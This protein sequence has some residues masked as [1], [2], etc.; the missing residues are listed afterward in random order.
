MKW[1]VV[2]ILIASQNIQR[3]EPI[4]VSE[5]AYLFAARDEVVGDALI[6]LADIFSKSK[7]EV[8]LSQ[9]AFFDKA[10]IKMWFAGRRKIISSLGLD[11]LDRVVG[12]LSES[13]VGVRLTEYSY[14]VATIEDLHALENMDLVKIT[15]DKLPKKIDK[16][17]SLQ[18]YWYLMHYVKAYQKL[19]GDGDIYIEESV[20]LFWN[21]EQLNDE[22]L[23]KSCEDYAIRLERLGHSEPL[24]FG[25]QPARRWC[26]GIRKIVNLPN[27]SILEGKDYEL[28]NIPLHESEEV[29]TNYLFSDDIFN[30]TEDLTYSFY[31]VSSLKDLE[32]FI[33][34]EVVTI[35][36]DEKS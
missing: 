9:N 18:M 2:H 21:K 6:D 7:A 27:F 32:K 33:N 3:P 20:N 12:G 24:S 30:L 15:V 35:E 22:E 4:G 11:A 23:L 26:A 36:Y 29:I 25:D 8:E 13:L 17:K 28:K 31:Y 16:V 10:H 1:Y 14:H 19:S 5:I 34:G